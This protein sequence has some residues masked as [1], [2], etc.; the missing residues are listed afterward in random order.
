MHA[1]YISSPTILNVCITILINVS[2]LRNYRGDPMIRYSIHHLLLTVSAWL[3][4]YTPIGSLYAQSSLP[5]RSQHPELYVTV[6]D[7][8][9]IYLVAAHGDT[10]KADQVSAAYEFDMLYDSTSLV[11]YSFTEC[12]RNVSRLRLLKWNDGR[13]VNADASLLSFNS[14]T[15]TFTCHIG[16]TLSFYREI[17][18]RDPRTGWMDTNSYRALDSLD[19]AVELVRTSD[20]TRAALLDSIGILPNLTEGRP[21]IHGMHP[22]MARVQYVVPSSLNNAKTFIRIRVYHRGSGE[23][24]FTRLDQITIALSNRLIDSNWAMF[25]DL[26]SPGSPK[27]IARDLHSLSGAAGSSLII[28]T[29]AG[30]SRDINISFESD[31]QGG[32]TA[33][34]IYDLMGQVIFFPYMTPGSHGRVHT[35]Y[36]F[37]TPGTFFIGLLHSNK[38]VA[39]RKIIIT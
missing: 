14:T 29:I 19:Y 10:I 26:F 4:L 36:H 18:W 1:P 2:W 11:I 28:N 5:P 3:F 21:I 8:V 16:D 6:Q 24:W 27:V 32:G 39:V 7:S 22:L 20:S 15:D 25:I 31:P 13:A 12:K 37:D 33:I 23:Y 9:A 34:A 17:Q 30:S 35:Q 38:I